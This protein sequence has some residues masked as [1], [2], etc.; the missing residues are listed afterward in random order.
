MLKDQALLLFVSQKK[1]HIFRF[2]EFSCWF[3]SYQNVFKNKDKN[4]LSKIYEA[5]N[6]EHDYMH[7]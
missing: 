3:Q 2:T 1:M 7:R 5:N 4:G 6:L